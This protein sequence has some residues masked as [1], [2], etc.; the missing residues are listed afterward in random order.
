MDI[1]KNRLTLHA[2]SERR[3]FIAPGTGFCFQAYGEL[4]LKR[5]SFG[6][7]DSDRAEKSS[8]GTFDLFVSC[9]VDGKNFHRQ[10]PPHR[11]KGPVVCK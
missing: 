4:R 2:L 8:Y 7:S 6:A 11:C 9:I 5:R 3:T 1:N 10:C